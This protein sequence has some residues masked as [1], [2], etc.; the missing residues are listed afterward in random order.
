MP[1]RGITCSRN[2]LILRIYIYIDAIY[3][4]V[5]QNI[6]NFFFYLFFFKNPVANMKDLIVNGYVRSLI[7]RGERVGVFEIICTEI[8]AITMLMDAVVTPLLR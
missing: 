6:L 2:Y 8:V 1:P 7:V 5:S 3:W 4:H